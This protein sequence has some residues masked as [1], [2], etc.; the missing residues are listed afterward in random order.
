[1]HFIQNN[2]KTFFV[3]VKKPTIAT[4]KNQFSLFETTKKSLFL[5]LSLALR[6]K[7][8]IAFKAFTLSLSVHKKCFAASST[9]Q[10]QFTQINFF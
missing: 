5:G 8:V 3:V 6:K 4:D 7:K 9:K 2:T 1:L 10:T